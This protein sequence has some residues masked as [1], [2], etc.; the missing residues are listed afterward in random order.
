MRPDATFTLRAALIAAALCWPALAAAEDKPVI[1]I[2]SKTIEASVTIDERLKAYPGLTDNLLAEGRRDVVKWR[3]GAEKDRKEMPDFFAKAAAIA[4][5]A[6]TP[7][8]R[9]SA[10]TSASCATTISTV[11]G[12]IRI[13]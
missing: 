12:R 5:S 6:P 11:S 7:G 1:A 10:A 3:A 4:T 9:R 8:A 2:D 13:R